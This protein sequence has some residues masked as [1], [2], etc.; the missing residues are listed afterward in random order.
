MTYTTKRR[1]GHV[2]CATAAGVLL[3]VGFLLLTENGLIDIPC[4]FR[5]LTGLLCPGCGNTGAARA[6]LHLDIATAFQRNPLCLLEFGYIAWVWIR[7]T[8]AY[9]RNGR[10][11]YRSPFIAGDIAVLC[12]VVL[13]GVLRN[14]L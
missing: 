2:L 4:P 6:L 13:W 9:I 10:F 1:I 14:F 5:K 8:T 7:S 3:I 12:F 11:C